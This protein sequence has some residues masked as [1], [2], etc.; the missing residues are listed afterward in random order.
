VDLTDALNSRSIEAGKLL[1][2]GRGAP[3][4]DRA[5]TDDQKSEAGK[6]YDALKERIF[7]DEMLKNAAAGRSR[8]RPGRPIAIETGVLPPLTVLR[9]SPRRNPALVTSRSAQ[10]RR[11]A[12][13]T[14]RAGESPSKR[15]MLHYNF[16]IQRRRGRLHARPA[17]AKSATAR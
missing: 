12:H 7:R 9:C 15:F 14:A 10:G 13:R 6:C 3:A 8:V 5:Y 16:R 11:T 2:R 1:P 17:A 4:R